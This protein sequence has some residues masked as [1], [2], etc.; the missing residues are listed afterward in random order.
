M[1]ERQRV[2]W[3]VSVAQQNM[4]NRGV[5][6]VDGEVIEAVLAAAA[7]NHSAEVALAI[8]QL[9]EPT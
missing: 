5:D 8:Q 1:N 6:S 2:A 9:T 4:S 3:L 7:G